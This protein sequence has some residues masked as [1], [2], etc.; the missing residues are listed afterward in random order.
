MGLRAMIF[1]YTKKGQG[2]AGAAVLLAIIAAFIVTYIILIPP[3]DRQELL[4]SSSS[5]SGGSSS[6]KM[7]TT[8][9]VSQANLMT[10]APGRVD[11]L[12]Q[13]DLEHTLPD[14]TLTSRSNSKIL[15]EKASIVATKGIFSEKKSSFSVAFDDLKNTEN[16]LLTYTPKVA[17]GK[18]MVFLNG[19]EI[20]SGNV[21][22]KSPKPLFLAKSAL[23]EEN[24]IEFTVASPGL[25]FWRTNELVLE[26]VRVIGDV[27]DIDAQV[28]KSLF[29]VSEVEKR[30][31]EKAILKFLLDCSELAG[32]MKVLLNGN[33]VYS[34]VP[35]CS[36]P[37]LTF[38]LSPS[39]FYDGQNTL[40]FSLDKGS[41][42]L[43]HPKIQTK[44]KEVVYPTFY[45]QVSL[46]QFQAVKNLKKKVY[47]TADFVDV[48]DAKTGEFVV[49][50]KVVS[51]NTKEGKLA[52]EVSNEIVQ[53]NNAVLIKPKKTVEI[54]ELKA[55]L[56]NN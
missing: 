1:T 56:V 11:Y 22:V 30:G 51:F 16:V 29:S 49:N 26:D 10:V 23:N 45:F 25:A 2:A 4:G 21:N 8:G 6:G 7:G 20:Y 46:E 50:G 47:L 15:A 42:I 35:D 18:M 19:Q 54:R 28:S 12:A 36:S 27:K 3:A 31:M 53:G 9:L 55:D 34:G 44:L 48:V 13:K 32:K 43:S 52:I 5:S 33:E 14:I 37:Q 17:E 38:E 39:L 24:I 40:L 41:V